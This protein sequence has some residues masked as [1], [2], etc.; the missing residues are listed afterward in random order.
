ML[1]VNRMKNRQQTTRK[2]KNMEKNWSIGRR[3][4][5][6]FC[7]KSNIVSATLLVL[8]GLCQGDSQLLLSSQNSSWDAQILMAHII[9]K[10]GMQ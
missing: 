2:K 5:S 3:L 7:L 1:K 4:F 8:F 10:T 9:R 6:Y